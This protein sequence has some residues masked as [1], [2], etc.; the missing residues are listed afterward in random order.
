VL[1]E[2]HWHGSSA[3]KRG[4]GNVC[5]PACAVNSPLS[6]FKPVR[7]SQCLHRVSRRGGE[8]SRAG[9]CAKARYAF[10]RNFGKSMTTILLKENE[11]FEVAIRRFRRAIEKNGLIAELRERQSYEKPTA[12]RKRKKAA[13]VKR[14]HKRLRSQML[15]K[16]LH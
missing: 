4:V 8:A 9:A 13:A 6:L 5:R 1:R 15:P 10:E 3:A 7:P 11:P 12:V 2:W 16:K 14:L